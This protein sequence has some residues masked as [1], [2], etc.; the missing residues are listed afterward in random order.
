MKNKEIIE[1][2]RKR[3]PESDYTLLGH[4]TKENR[5]GYTEPNNYI[6]TEE[7]EEFITKA[8]TSQR[9][10]IL[11]ELKLYALSKDF[12]AIE[13]IKNEV[14]DQKQKG[15]KKWIQKNFSNAIRRLGGI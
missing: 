2:F 15:T 13:D 8:L 9:E 11:K 6:A 3:F 12:I 1:E 10:E 7:I 4:G 14:L 5:E